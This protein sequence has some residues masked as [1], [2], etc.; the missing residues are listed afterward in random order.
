MAVRQD[1]EGKVAQSIGHRLH[2]LCRTRR[3]RV[4]KIHG[5]EGVAG[6]ED[7]RRGVLKT[8][9]RAVRPDGLAQVTQHRPPDAETSGERRIPYRVVLME[10]IHAGNALGSAIKAR[11]RRPCNHSGANCFTAWNIL[12]RKSRVNRRAINLKGSLG[13]FIGAAP[14][15]ERLEQM[16][17]TLSRESFVGT[18]QSG[19]DIPVCARLRGRSGCCPTIPRSIAGASPARAPQNA[20]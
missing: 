17:D 13:P 4:H 20:L 18:A 14:P 7:I 10:R 8:H 6:R 1:D 19:A 2:L 15:A 3:K 5:P 11:F 16:R 9:Y 12:Y